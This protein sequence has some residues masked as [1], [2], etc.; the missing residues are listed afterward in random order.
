MNVALLLVAAALSLLLIYPASS[1][2][3]MTTEDGA[4]GGEIPGGIIPED[5]KVGPV[6]NTGAEYKFDD[7]FYQKIQ[8]LIPEDPEEG[9]YGVYDGTRY[10]DVLIVVSRDDGD[11]RGADETARE[12]K[13]AVVK[14][15]ELVGARNIVSA[16][17]LSFVTASVPVADIPGFS[18]HDEVYAIGDGELPVTLEVDKARETIHAT[19]NEIRRA[20]GVALSGTGVTVGVVDNGINSI[21]LNGKVSERIYCPENTCSVVN[22]Q[23]VG[24]FIQDMSRLA[25]LNDTYA[26]HGTRVAHVLAASGAPNNIGIAPGVTLLDARYGDGYGRNMH[27]NNFITALAHSVDWSYSRG[28]DVVNISAGVLDCSNADTTAYNHILNEAVDKGMVVVKSAGNEGEDNAGNPRYQSISNPGCSHNVITVG[29][30]DDRVGAIEMANFTSRGPTDNSQPRLVPHIV[31]PAYKIE[32]ANLTTGPTLI[33]RNGTS[34]AAPQVSAVAAMMLQAEPELTPAEVKAALLLG[35]DWQGPAS[36]TSAQYEQNRP[37]DNCSYARQPTTSLNA[38]NAASL[39][40][41]NNVGFG[42]LDAAQSVKYVKSLTSYVV[43]DHLTPSSTLKQYRFTVTDASEPVKVILTWLAQPHGG[44]GEQLNRNKT[45][46]IANLDLGITAPNRVTTW[47]NSTHQT[48]EFIVFDPTRTGTYTVTVSGSG[49]DIKLLNKPVQAFALASTNPLSEVSS[50]TTVTNHAPTAQPRTLIVSPGMEKVVRLHATDSDSDVVSFHVSQKPSKGVVTTDE[51]LTE[52]VSRAVYTPNT[53]FTGT[54]TFRVTPHDGK[55]QGTAANITLRAE[56]LPAGSSPANPTSDYVRD[57]DTLEVTSGFAHTSYSQTFAGRTYAVSA[58]HIGSV[59]MEGVDLSITTTSG[60]TYTAAVPPSGARMI[61]FQSPITIRSATLSADGIDEEAAHDIT[62]YLENQSSSSYTSTYGDVR[63]FVGYVP[64]ACSSGSSGAAGS[65]SAACPA[66]AT[67]AATTKPNLGIPDNTDMQDTSSI[68]VMPINGTIASISTTVDITHTYIG[69]LK[70][71][72]ASPSGSQAVLH[73]RTGGSTDNISA[74]YSSNTHTGLGSLHGAQINGNWTLSVGDYAGGDVGTLN[75]WTVAITYVPP[76]PSTPP[77]PTQPPSNTTVFM[78]DF[79]SS[80]FTAKWAETGEG[81]WT[82]STSS[83]HSVPTAPG[84]ASTNKVAHVDNCDTTC[85]LTLKN[86]L[87]LSGYDSATLSFLRFVDYGLDSGEYLEVELYDGTSWNQVYRWTHGSGDDNIWHD[88]SYDLSSYLVSGFKARFVAHMSIS[89]EDVQLDDIVINA[90]SSGSGSPAPT[91]S[92][93]SVYVADTDDREVLVFSKNGTYLDGFVDR[94]AGG[95]GKAWDLDFGPDGH[96]Y[97]SDNTYNKIRKYNGATGAPIGSSSTGWASTTGFPN[98]LTWE[99]S[100]LYVA[101]SRGVEK[102]SSSGSSLG[103]FGDAH[104]SPATT[105]APALVSPQDVVFCSDSR[106][107]V[108]DKSLGKVLYYK[109]SDGKYLG[110]L[111]ST[112][113]SPPNMRAATGLECGP[114]MTGSGTSLYQSGDDGG[115]VNEISLS[116]ESLVRSTTSLIDEPYCMDMD[117]AGVLYVA[118]KDDD[119]IVK[120]E[121][122]ASSVFASGNTMDDPRG[123]TVGPA[124]SAAGASGQGSPSQPEEVQNDEPEF[125]LTYNGTTTYGPIILAAQTTSFT[126]QATDPEGDAITIGIIPDHLLPDG[127]MTVTDHQNGTATVTVSSANATA[128]TYALWIKV[129]DTEG[130]YD[131]QPYAVIV[132]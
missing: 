89:S 71:V 30:I 130:N 6:G 41:L 102:F 122:G 1:M 103:Y 39:G 52:N 51:M 11:D 47:S 40:I 12:N 131:R 31:A 38:N 80:S 76:P 43:S 49:S 117:G 84:H 19:P 63:M 98:G 96:L 60:R 45:V 59:N 113:S 110:N 33:D 91:P 23:L 114:A 62:K 46:H 116:T 94:R 73:S 126:V 18:L 64:S 70:V 28:A 26:S 83:A 101:T 125:V 81:D 119:N 85:T 127:A 79:E 129:S 112:A 66:Q 69:D 120:I 121:S 22:G 68:I 21:Y 4:G 65:S 107:Y 29:G 42:I 97:V 108:S 100:V 35:A 50:S 17:S 95:L 106:M 32:I 99:D 7:G 20:A 67:Y 74:T 86:S 54:D 128:G 88:E 48:T 115:R 8:G 13:D 56:S 87:D 55:T 61:E 53:N 90:T 109:A 124:Y 72:L 9:D 44:I 37:A 111:S 25:N 92:D 93:Y 5:N 105:G 82:I 34:Y 27:N 15:L 57:W 118:N 14:Q 75:S 132:R 24:S 77:S 58:I 3:Q 123:V 10:Y 78:D 2:S 16:E 104:R 36:C